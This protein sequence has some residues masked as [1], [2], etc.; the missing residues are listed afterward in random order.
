MRKIVLPFS[1]LVLPALVAPSLAAPSVAAPTAKPTLKASRTA[2]GV[3]TTP[4]LT[5][6]SYVSSELDEE[7]LASS[8][9]WTAPLEATAAN[10]SDGFEA[11]VSVG[12]RNAGNSW[13]LRVVGRD[14]SATVRFWRVVN[15]RVEK[16]GEPEATLPLA[17]GK[18]SGQ[19]TLQRASGRVRALWNG[20]VMVTAWGNVPVGPFGLAA[21]RAKW[22][23]ERLNPTANV[24]FSDDFMRASAPDE[25]ETAGEW[26]RLT[27]VWK[28]SGLLGPRADA[29]K[30]PNP[31]VFRAQNSSPGAS[32]AARPAMATAGKWFWS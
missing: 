13:L 31:F 4:L 22:G 28:T 15:G 30:N 29:D 27:G 9:T 12:A 1:I 23:K 7:D 8:W 6:W 25:K 21:R 2:P 18:L 10:S 14:Q 26:K 19:L 11:R 20:R 17:G 3:T 32:S 16:F 24:V 5:G